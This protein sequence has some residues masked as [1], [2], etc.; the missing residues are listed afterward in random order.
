MTSLAERR[1]LATQDG[2]KF[3]FRP[4]DLQFE[5]SQ[6]EN[7]FALK[8]NKSVGETLK[9]RRYAN[10]ASD[11]EKYLSLL[12]IPLGEF[13]LKLKQDGDQFYKRFLNKHGDM[14][15]STF[16]IKNPEF[17]GGRGLYAYYVGDQLRYIG[18]C[19]DNIKKRI[20][21]GYGK[22]HPKNCYID[23]QSTNCR[24]NSKITENRDSISLWFCLIDDD[25]EIDSAEKHLIGN[26]C[27]AWNIQR[28]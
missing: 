4:V 21:Q 27:P 25:V 7:V 2:A 11:A 26:H 9:H 1:E 12:D 16:S 17:L 23:G 5:G 10:L 6:R 22:I 19:R 20:N 28:T 13:L 14:R 3:V 24:L 18:R 15:Y 8:N